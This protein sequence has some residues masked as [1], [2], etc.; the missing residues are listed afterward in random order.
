MNLMKERVRS[1]GEE[2]V[3]AAT[4]GFGAI[5]IVAALPFLLAAALEHGGSLAVVSASI[6][7]ATAM[8]LYVASM[9]Y[10]AVPPG[11]LKSIF[12]AADHS[13]IFLLIAG[14]YTPFMLG[15]LRGPWGWSLFGVIWGLALLG[16]L[17]ECSGMRRIR[18]FSVGLYLAMGW[19]AVVAIVPMTAH[20]QFGGLVLIFAGGLAYTIGTVFYAIEQIPYFHA[21]W[22]LFVLAG[23]GCHFFA[24]MNYAA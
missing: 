21:V 1:V 2:M 20:V 11:R 15:V 12:Q 9:L 7:A 22:H 13:A 6:F 5:S 24:V 8:S 14:T 19:L 3:N 18:S 10:H 16:L 4:H 23:T 17:A